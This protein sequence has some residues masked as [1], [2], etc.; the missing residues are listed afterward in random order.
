MR[1]RKT[2]FLQICVIITGLFFV[3]VGFVFYLSPPVFGKMMMIEV[4]EEWLSQM[5][6]DEFLVMITVYSRLVSLLMFF[7]GISMIM[8]LF[9]PLKYRALIYFFGFFFPF[10]A[11]VSAVIYYFTLGRQLTTIIIGAFF[12][13]IFVLNSTGLIM[14]KKDA[15][16]GIE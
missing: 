9:D 11:A 16:M 12:F 7:A 8:P 5:R 3:T 14:T 4:G 10:F 2:N 15:G 6:L 1:S 13:L